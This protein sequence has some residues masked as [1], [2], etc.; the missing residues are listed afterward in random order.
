[1]ASAIMYLGFRSFL[2]LSRYHARAPSAACLP[3]DIY[4]GGSELEPIRSA[5]PKLW[6]G[7]RSQSLPPFMPS[8]I[9][10]PGDLVLVTGA[11][12]TICKLLESRAALTSPLGAGFL[13]S[14]VCEALMRAGYRVR[15]TSRSVD[16]VSSLQ[17]RWDIQFPGQFESVIIPDLV[18]AGAADDALQGEQ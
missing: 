14:H 15:G 4:F 16:L 18:E 5:R 9:L 13:A 11:D 1:M 12:G 2:D 7:G 3:D 10:A 17:K 8:S 6:G